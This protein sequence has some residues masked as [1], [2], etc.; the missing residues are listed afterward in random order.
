MRNRLK[1]RSLRKVRTTASLKGRFRH[2]SPCASNFI[3]L[4]KFEY[5]HTPQQCGDGQVWKLKSLFSN[6]SSLYQVE[7]RANQDKRQVGRWEGREAQEL[8]VS[9]SPGSRKQLKKRVPSWR[10][11]LLR[12][13]KPWAWTGIRD[14]KTDLKT[15]EWGYHMLHS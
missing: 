4:F 9:E 6:D 8:P 5:V 3:S 10:G 1:G 12:D 14:N 7:K 2:A 13:D 15:P 11:A